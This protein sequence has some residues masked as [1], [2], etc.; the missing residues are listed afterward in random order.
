MEYPLRVPY[1]VCDDLI[2][3]LRFCVDC[4]ALGLLEIYGPRHQLDSSFEAWIAGKGVWVQIVGKLLLLSGGGK[5]LDAR[6]GS[7]EHAFHHSAARKK[8]KKVF[9]GPRH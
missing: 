7:L 6:L 4:A 5:R 1:V 9:P 8:V 3:S 2:L